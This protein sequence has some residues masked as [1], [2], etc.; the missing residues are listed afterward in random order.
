MKKD[1]TSARAIIVDAGS[2][3]KISWEPPARIRTAIATM[4]PLV[5]MGFRAKFEPVLELI[6]LT[7][8]GIA[9]SGE[10]AENGIVALANHLGQVNEDHLI[11]LQQA[12]TIRSGKATSDA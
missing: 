3:G 2:A 11:L 9:L 8:G 6:I 4:D 12:R 5:Q 10:H 1:A 7:L